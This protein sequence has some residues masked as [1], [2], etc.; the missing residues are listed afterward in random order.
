[1]FG[2]DN[3]IF[4][5]D[6]ASCHRV[7]IVNKK[8]TQGQCNGLQIARISIQLKICGGNLRTW[9][10]TRLQPAKLIYQQQSE[11]VGASLMKS[12]VCHSLK[13]KFGVNQSRAVVQG[14]RVLLLGKSMRKFDAT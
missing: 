12:T 6:A 8:N 2:D 3:I 4:Q 1:M 7:K 11:K 14:H 5:D 10:M 9:S 13:G